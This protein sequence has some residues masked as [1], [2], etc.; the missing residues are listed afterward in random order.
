VLLNRVVDDPAADS[1]SVDNEAGGRRIGEEIAAHG[2]RLP[3]AILGPERASTARDRE[4]GFRAAL[5]AHGLE[6]PPERV[7][8]GPFTFEAG[9]DGMTRLLAADPRPTVVFCGNDVI[10]LGAL[11]AAR[12]AG[13]AV[14]DELSVVGFDD[15]GMAAWHA[16]RLTTVR[17]DLRR[18][19]DVAVE[20]LHARVEDPLVAPR[21]VVLPVEL[22]RRATLAAPPGYSTKQ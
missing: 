21:Q 19:A 1:C 14:P 12:T 22:V 11:D 4:A 6:L 7:A 10:A 5:A 3:A 17:Q 9:S 16:F 18:M 8:R 13:V 15:I 2:H 20:L